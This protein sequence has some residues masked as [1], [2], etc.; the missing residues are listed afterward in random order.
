MDNVISILPVNQDPFL[1]TWDLGR[2]CNYDCSYCPAHRHD[3]FSSHASLD[4]L[5]NTVDFL[6]EYISVISEYR[7]NK[8]FYISFTGGEPTVNPAFKEFAAYLKTKKNTHNIKLDLTTNGAMSKSVAESI[9][10]C[11]DHVTVSYHAEANTSTKKQVLERILFLNQSVPVKVNVMMHS[12]EF[13]DCVEFCNTLK[14]HG[15]KFIPRRIGEDPDAKLTQAHAYTPSQLEWFKQEWNIDVTP[16]TRPCCGGRTFGV[17]NSAGITE[18]KYVESREFK[19]WSCSVNW[20]F[21]HVEQQTKLVYTHQ[22]CQARLDGTRGSIGDLDSW[23]TIVSDLK[24]NLEQ[25]AMPIIV[26]PNKLCGC[27]L[28]T[29]KSK[30]RQD[31]LKT[32]PAVVKDISI[33]N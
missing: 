21:L 12:R 5:K 26:C 28:C 6:F 9:I 23:E 4:E 25:K 16:S 24:A 15:V 17:C 20:Y 3:N 33:F 27:G 1:I 18:T 29:P 32:L 7:I 10:D 2:R 30:N 22:T 11:F 13:E 8:D 31:L 19:D 14:E